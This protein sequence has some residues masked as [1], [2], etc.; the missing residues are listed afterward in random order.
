MAG[1]GLGDQVD[2]EVAPIPGDSGSIA[3]TDVGKNLVS[4]S[5]TEATDN[6]TIGRANLDGSTVETIATASDGL[7]WPLGIAVDPG[8]STLIVA[9]D[10]ADALFS[11]GLDGSGISTIVPSISDAYEVEIDAV[12]EKVY[13]VDRAAPAVKRAD[14][15]GGNVETVLDGSDGLSYPEGLAPHNID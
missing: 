11:M 7:G 15:D 14:L 9:D 5:S 3:T 6:D 12:G 1:S 10:T 4:L 13:W 8:T 2:P